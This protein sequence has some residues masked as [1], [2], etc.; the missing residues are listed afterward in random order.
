MNPRIAKELRLIALPL[1]LSFA[2][3]I[4]VSVMA[5]GLGVFAWVAACS[6]IVASAFVGDMTPHGV[7]FSM[8]MPVTRRTVW[9]EKAMVVAGA[10]LLLSLAFGSVFWLWVAYAEGAVSLIILG[11]AVPLFLFG[12]GVSLAIWTRNPVA[13][14]WLAILGMGVVL[15]VTTL[16][17]PLVFPGLDQLYVFEF[18]LIVAGII[19]IRRG[20]RR[21]LD[22][23]DNDTF[24]TFATFD[25]FAG[26]GRI[27]G[28]SNRR[29]TTGALGALLRK[30]FAIQQINIIL[31]VGAL[32][33]VGASGIW[34]S[35]NVFNW[36][37][38]LPKVVAL[39]IA[40][41]TGAAAFAEERNMGMLPWI[42]T[43]PVTRRT[44][45]RLKLVVALSCALVL[46]GGG[47]IVMDGVMSLSASHVG[48]TPVHLMAP[49]HFI[50]LCLV[51]PVAACLAGAFASS[52]SRSFLTALSHT[53]LIGIAL[54]GL[55]NVFGELSYL[56]DPYHFFAG[57]GLPNALIL[58]TSL[59]V[60]LIV[61]LWM[62]RRNFVRDTTGSNVVLRSYRALFIAAVCLFAVNAAIFARVWE[63]A[64]PLPSDARFGEPPVGNTSL[65]KPV[66]SVNGRLAVLQDGS[67]WWIRLY[68]PGATGVWKTRPLER[69][70]TN[71]DWVDVVGRYAGY[72]AL[73]SDGSLWMGG[74]L[75]TENLQPVPTDENGLMKSGTGS[76]ELVFPEPV[77][78]SPG[79]RWKLLASGDRSNETTAIRED[80]TLWTWGQPEWLPNPGRL[81]T[82]NNDTAEL[83]QIGGDN[84]WKD[85]VAINGVYVGLKTDGSMWIW[86]N[87]NPQFLG[88]GLSVEFWKPERLELDA[89]VTDLI[90]V[91]QTGF[92][93][94]QE[95]GA[96]VT[97]G[98]GLTWSLLA[99]CSRPEGVVIDRVSNGNVR[100]PTWTPELVLTD[101][102][103]IVAKSGRDL[104]GRG[105]PG[106]NWTTLRWT[107]GFT[108]DGSYW[109]FQ[110]ESEEGPLDG[111]AVW[112]NL[113][114][115]MEDRYFIPPRWRPKLVGKLE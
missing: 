97:F 16:A 19:G 17:V 37:T 70:G 95:N 100:T 63:F 111:F 11:I 83:H 79:I 67:L 34:V 88:L 69:I 55:Y 94:R 40:F 80:G 57:A 89:A 8:T 65:K 103:G 96:A 48:F 31:T 47:M 71:H 15:I 44:Q 58:T 36:V 14:F 23:E 26:I 112:L 12:T 39:F 38:W 27:L 61:F 59:P 60:L 30:E 87:P 82:K 54:A 104:Y 1:T 107:G 32:V 73:K 9:R 18:F 76:Q 7:S 5:G 42:L 115:G 101:D 2:L 41:A 78:V 45:F 84:D 90:S 91:S 105:I 24:S 64:G 81:E 56:A 114:L 28:R 110:D 99:S 106:C 22:F 13:T 29:A 109:N 86:G 62:C 10:L 43:F 113:R 51:A 66:L 33:V 102:D 93:A 4:G 98:D 50:L 85:V 74:T 20:R 108:R 46:A 35:Q 68:H 77:E 52:F 25:L 75:R 6:I 21:F 3:V 92:V 72:F 53:L 49:A